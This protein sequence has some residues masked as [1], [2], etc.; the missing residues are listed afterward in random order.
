MPSRACRLLAVNLKLDIEIKSVNLTAGEHNTPEFVKLNP[1]RQVPVLV[2]GD[3]VLCESRAILAYL[4]NKF[5]PDSELYPV[6]ARKRAVIDQRLFYDA[7]VVFEAAVQIVVSETKS[8]RILSLFL[9][10]SLSFCSAR[11]CSSA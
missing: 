6:D 1:Q 8:L 9:R 2:D 3:F 10:H 5:Q 11:C 7:T 4:V